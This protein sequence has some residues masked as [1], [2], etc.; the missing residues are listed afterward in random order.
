MLENEF[1]K[2]K[3]E[4]Q[5]REIINVLVIGKIK[6]S[7]IVAVIFYL[8]FHNLRK[9]IPNAS[10]ICITVAYLLSTCYRWYDLLSAFWVKIGSE[11]LNIGEK[12]MLII[13]LSRENIDS[14]STAWSFT[15]SDP[16]NKV[17]NLFIDLKSVWKQLDYL[18]MC[19]RSIIRFYLVV[20]PH[21]EYRIRNDGE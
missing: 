20:L 18:M 2:A 12:I 4:K 11:R 15:S 10:T 21:I 16:C 9:I 1:Q 13:K 17:R 6:I 14:K 3:V 8:I 19:A 7:S 5:K